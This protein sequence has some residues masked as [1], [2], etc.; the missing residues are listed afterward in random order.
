VRHL[1]VEQHQGNRLQCT[2]FNAGL[3]SLCSF[4]N[5]LLAVNAKCASFCQ[6]QR[7]HLFFDYRHVEKLVFRY[8]DSD[9]IPCFMLVKLNI[10]CLL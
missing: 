5:R 6:I 3:D 1:K 10:R 2:S 8:N 7:R 9:F 4:I